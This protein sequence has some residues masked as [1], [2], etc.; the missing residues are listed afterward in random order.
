MFNIPATNT[1]GSS[2]GCQMVYFQTK[3]T[4]L[5]KFWRALQWKIL[6]NFITIWSIL[7]QL[8]IFYDHLVYFVVFLLYFSGSGM[9][10]QEKSG[11]P[12]SNDRVYRKV[13]WHIKQ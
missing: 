13:A 4:N 1:S 6:V 10:Y 9:L 5:G 3:N 11:K 2:Q 12:G 7:L 8:G